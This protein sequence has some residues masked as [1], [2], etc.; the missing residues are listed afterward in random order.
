MNLVLFPVA[1]TNI[2]PISNSHS[3]GQLLTEYNLRSRESVGTDMNVTY[4][5]GP[6]YTHSLDDFDVT[7]ELDGSGTIISSTSLTISAGRALVN[8][9]YVESLV[10]VDIDLEECNA[11]LQD[12]GMTVLKGKLCIGLRIMYSTSQTMNGAMMIENDS[13]YYTGVQVVILP[14]EGN[15]GE[16]FTLPSDSPTDESKVNAHLKLAEFT[17]TNGSIT[18]IIRNDDKISVIS[19]ERISSVTDFI[20]DIYVKKTGLDPWKIYTFAGNGSDTQYDTWCDSM[21]SL[22][23]WDNDPQTSKG[24]PNGVASAT[25]WYNPL[26]DSVLL[27]LPHKQPD[28][29]IYGSNNEQWHYD[30]KLI[31]LP[32]ANYGL[33]TGGVVTKSYT[34]IIRNIDNKIQTFYR[35]P[36]GKM[37][38]YYDG[39]LTAKKKSEVFPNFPNVYE[40]STW[41]PGD[42][43][44]ISQDATVSD[45][46]RSIIDTDINVDTT[47]I[48]GRFPSTMYVVLP[49]RVT[50]IAYVGYTANPEEVPPSLVDGTPIGRATHTGSEYDYSNIP[51]VS[52][53]LGLENGNFR[54]IVNTDYFVVQWDNPSGSLINT[55][56]YFYKVSTNT[57]IMQF[58]ENPIFVTA[59][60][61][62]AQDNVVGGFLN[63]PADSIGGGYVYRDEYGHL[64]LADYQI[65]ASG[66][67][68]Y[69]L[70][71][72]YKISG[73]MS[74][75]QNVLD[76]YVNERVA[77]PN[78]TQMK[79]Y[80]KYNLENGTNESPNNIHLHIELPE[81]TADDGQLSIEIRN[82]DSRFSTPVYIH[83]TG[84]GS[85]YT[86]VN[87]VNCE[88]VRI[89]I[90]D[91]EPVVQLYNSCL[92]YDSAIMDGLTTITGL[93]LWYEKLSS[94]DPDI[95]V[96]GMTVELVG[97]PTYNSN[98]EDYWNI[99]TPNDNHYKYALRGI[100][101]GPDG[102]V[103]G[104]S[105]YV[106]D[107][108]TGN[109]REGNYIFASNFSL[110]QG[111]SLQYPVT[112]LTK[113]LKVTGTFVT[114]YP[115]SNYQPI[116]Y[117]TK[118][119]T[120]TAYTDPYTG[121]SANNY[122][123]G[124][125]SFF[126]KIVNVYNV[127]GDI[128]AT[129]VIDGWATGQYHVF[130]GGAVE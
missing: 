35:L 25:F 17:F 60:I 50:G 71:Q 57:G 118:E 82:I 41:I 81:V 21:D 69:Q 27:Q 127:N 104:L 31:P 15:V 14:K 112:K 1:S 3:G 48:Y 109:N 96:N 56:Y 8:G 6:S 62:F 114:A 18:N 93:T 4:A 65:L 107:D 42:Y 16:R 11:Y 89:L 83:L 86:I 117:T 84:S 24:A 75:I 80:Q 64:R 73:T 39:I 7:M 95:Q 124:T 111:S 23:I 88:K 20:S 52:E 122:V 74:E 13:G 61:P 45:Q 59:T 28:G 85:A 128:P 5:I 106:T 44:L 98:D 102:C 30:D 55:N 12:R 119:T 22:M 87:I 67:L 103:N 77:F 113:P 92:Y 99:S 66:V 105:L 53:L 130:Y 120:F 125:I 26:E 101:F 76:Q 70:G 97:S 90:D 91:G 110:P 40:N 36:Q 49:P 47:T 116:G 72:D 68:A 100:T 123:T 19:A 10:P 38:Y 34:D 37:R 129:Q 126:T 108:I 51:Y 58:S 121:N 54:G 43:A 33:G 46:M 29:G 115:I 9:H 79:N 94:S 78:A 32:S 2:F 63:V